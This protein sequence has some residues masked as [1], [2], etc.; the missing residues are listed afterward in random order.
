MQKKVLQIIFR[1]QK[2]EV[3]RINGILPA[4]SLRYYAGVN[5]VFYM[6]SYNITYFITLNDKYFA[7]YRISHTR[8]FLLN[9]ML[10]LIFLETKFINFLRYLTI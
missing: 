7:I 2:S 5:T 9:L 8:K 4:L 1:S 6:F 3:I 10:I